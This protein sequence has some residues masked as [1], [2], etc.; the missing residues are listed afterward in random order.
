MLSHIYFSPFNHPSYSDVLHVTSDIRPSHFSH[1]M[2]KLRVPWGQSYMYSMIVQTG[3]PAPFPG[4]L[5]LA[6]TLGWVGN[7]AFLH[8]VCHQFRY[9]E[10][11]CKI[12]CGYWPI[13]IGFIL[14]DKLARGRTTNHSSTSQSTTTSQSS[15]SQSST[16]QFKFTMSFM[17][18]VISIPLYNVF[19]LIS[20]LLN[21]GYELYYAPV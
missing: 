11:E 4:V 13:C 17:L 21:S 19:V 1:T 16:S 3:Q 5:S 10:T 14:T 2:L 7:Q 20:Q 6:E 18:S 12:T 9:P 8:K 15:A